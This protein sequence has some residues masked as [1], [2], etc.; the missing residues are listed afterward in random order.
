MTAAGAERNCAVA[1]TTA[2]LR[3]QAACTPK[4]LKELC[5]LGPDVAVHAPA[6]QMT[7]SAADEAEM[8]RTRMRRRVFDIISKARSPCGCAGWRWRLGVMPVRVWA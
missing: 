6:A 1:T 7:L 8:A 4:E 5:G 3:L 2:I